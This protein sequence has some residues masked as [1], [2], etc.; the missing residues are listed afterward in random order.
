MASPL[1]RAAGLT[2][3]GTCAARE[4]LKSASVARP[5]KTLQRTLMPNLLARDLSRRCSFVGRLIP[6]DGLEGEGNF[7][8]GMAS[9]GRQP[10]VDAIYKGLTPPAR[11]SLHQIAIG[12]V[13]D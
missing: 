5:P 8:K 2:C 1:T 3:C 12:V 10:L 13:G 9:G 4:P 6:R 7:L 11:Q